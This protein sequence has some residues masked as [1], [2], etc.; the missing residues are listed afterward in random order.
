MECVYISEIQIIVLPKNNIWA[1]L[2]LGPQKG[3]SWT[4]MVPKSPP[5]GP[6][7]PPMGPKGPFGGRR[8]TKGALGPYWGPWLLSPLGW[9][10]VSRCL[11]SGIILRSWISCQDQGAGPAA[12]F[13][14]Y[15]DGWNDIN[16]MN[17][18]CKKH[19]ECLNGIEAWMQA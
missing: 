10:L 18:M 4:P 2:G 16:T 17:N 1:H 11:L 14:K 9:L 13:Q 6:K 8:P 12:G 15:W 19:T 7:G 5:L 3:P